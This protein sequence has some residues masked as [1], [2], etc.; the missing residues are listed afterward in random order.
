[1]VQKGSS[2]YV[3]DNSGARIVKCIQVIGRGFGM[4]VAGSFCIVSVK[5]YNPVKKIRKGELHYAVI[6]AI[7]KRFLRINGFGVNFD[8]NYAVLVNKKAV[9]I[10]TRVLGPVMHE[11]RWSGFLKVASMAASSV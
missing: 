10:C 8:R 3:I 4:G 6:V 5:T 2:L 7:R 1:M 11:V 9:P